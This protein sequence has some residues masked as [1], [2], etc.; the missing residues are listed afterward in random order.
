MKTHDS[1]V[2]ETLSDDEIAC[3]AGSVR[4]VGKMPRAQDMYGNTVSMEE[5]MDLQLLAA[6]TGDA[7]LLWD[8]Y[9]TGFNAHRPNI[10]T[11]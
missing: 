6:K 3:V 10:W 8:Y 1:S 11:D 9:E 7:N 5:Y 2:L 4:E